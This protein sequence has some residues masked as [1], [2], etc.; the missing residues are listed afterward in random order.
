MASG[1]S[2]ALQMYQ[3]FDGLGKYPYR[4][5]CFI[6]YWRQAALSFAVPLEA[7]SSANHGWRVREM[8]IRIFSVSGSIAIP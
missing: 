4:G 2:A 1:S 7:E 3:D 6:K 5:P 8:A